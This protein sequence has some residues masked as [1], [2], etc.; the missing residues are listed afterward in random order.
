MI[1]LHTLKGDEYV[2]NSFHIERIESIPDTVITLTNEKKFI[3][4]ESP[5]DIISLIIEFQNKIK[6]SNNVDV[7]NSKS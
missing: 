7:K 4:K 2:L 6:V 1:V 3:V 5:K